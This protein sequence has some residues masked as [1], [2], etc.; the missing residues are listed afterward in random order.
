MC[1]VQ[2][3]G[4]HCHWFM[5]CT[6]LKTPGSA[7]TPIGTQQTIPSFKKVQASSTVMLRLDGLNTVYMHEWLCVY[8]CT[9][10]GGG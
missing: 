7:H 8:V 9:V 2:Q 4:I 3:S 1:A 6:G 10:C 5:H